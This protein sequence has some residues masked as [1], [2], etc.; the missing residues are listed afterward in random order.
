ME[1]VYPP[2]AV[3]SINPSLLASDRNAS[4][5]VGVCCSLLN[6]GIGNDCEIRKKK[7]SNVATR[8]DEGQNI[9]PGCHDSDLH[10]L[11]PRESD[12]TQGNRKKAAGCARPAHPARPAIPA[13]SARPVGPALYIIRMYV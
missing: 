11:D 4:A 13:G 7:H 12:R 1:K 3:S 10:K 8:S 6:G 9:F 2:W 5:G